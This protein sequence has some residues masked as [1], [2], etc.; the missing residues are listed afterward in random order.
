MSVKQILSPCLFI[1]LI[2]FLVPFFVYA[3]S[4]SNS[5]S[6]A[7]QI[8]SDSIAPTTPGPVTATPVTFSQI[9]VSWGASTDDQ[10]LSGYLLFRDGVH[11]ATT[12][13][14]SYSD[15]GLTA[16]TT[17]TYTVQAYD[18]FLNISSTSA[19]VATTTPVAPSPPV[20]TPTENTSANTGTRVDPKLASF[21]ITTT[22]TTADI[23]W[24]T[25]IYVQFFLRWGK[26]SAYDLGFVQSGSFKKEHQ[27]LID[28]LEPGTTYDYELIGYTQQGKE[29]LLSKSSFTTEASP[30]LEAPANVS[31]L[32]ASVEGDSVR[33]TWINPEDLDFTKVRIVRNYNFYPGDPSNGYIAYEGSAEMFF[34]SG[35]LRSYDGQYYSIFTYDENGNISS[36]AVVVARK[37]SE[38]DSSGAVDEQNGGNVDTRSS[39]TI[40]NTIEID[41]SQ[42][43]VYQHE[44]Q[45]FPVDG[46]ATVSTNAPV[47]VKI[48]YELLPEHL[49]TILVTFNAGSKQ[50]VS[51]M[52]RINKNKTAYEAVVP[53]LGTEGL[54]QL[55]F[56]IYDFQTQLLTTFSGRLFAEAKDDNGST[57]LFFG[58]V[59][60]LR[61]IPILSGVAFLFMLLFFFLLFLRRRDDED[62]YTV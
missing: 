57:G 53:S 34:D 17:Y 1:V 59:N 61:M 41:F 27:T 2:V 18:W 48:P 39:T 12:S 10:S 35:V 24:T 50:A 14:L 13:L 58:T 37:L 60:T 31:N 47:K 7:Q 3:Q 33:L 40:I 44:I 16:S 55:Q 56:S 51:Y 9:D 20:V 32:Q 26:G 29:Y 62:K 4:S 15:T 19:P 25:N 23:S 30:D 6:V 8:G 28:G 43:E 52:L 46:V 45:V 22:Q 36:G 38:S 42:V 5:F 21:E 11:V 49:K 54:Y